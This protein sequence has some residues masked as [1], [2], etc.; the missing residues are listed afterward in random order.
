MVGSP[1]ADSRNIDPG[2]ALSPLIWIC[3]SAEEPSAVTFSADVF[4]EP[5]PFR[6][7]FGFV[8]ASIKI[9][10][11]TLGSRPMPG[12]QLAFAVHNCF[13]TASAT[14]LKSKVKPVA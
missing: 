1:R 7:Y 13:G 2:C 4:S 10:F 11:T 14:T 5:D 9:T 3:G 12:P 8:W 6:L